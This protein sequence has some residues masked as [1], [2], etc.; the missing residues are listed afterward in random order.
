[1]TDVRQQVFE[2]VDA[3]P[4]VHYSGLVRELDIAAGQAQYHLRRLLDARRLHVE[5]IQGRTHYFTDGYDDWERRTIALLRRETTRQVIV[6]ALDSDGVSAMELADE[7]DLARSTV[8][9]HLSTLVEADVAEKYYDSKARAHLRLIRPSE[10][11]ELLEEVTP[12]LS[13]RLVDRFT[14]LIDASFHG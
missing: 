14:R 5:K 8:S 12:S 10:T 4:G 6:Y 7:L 11:R 9:W 3:H 1:M 13:D 2:H